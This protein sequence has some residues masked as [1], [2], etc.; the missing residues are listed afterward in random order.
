MAIGDDLSAMLPPP[1]PP[2]PMRRD[3]T[4]AAALRR[5]DG[6]PDLADPAV[7]AA[8]PGRLHTRRA[9]VLASVLLVAVIGVPATLI[10]LRDRP[11]ET[12]REATSTQGE[13]APPPPTSAAPSA[14]APPGQVARDVS[15]P[16]ADRAQ[17]GAPIP[18][19]Q[20]KLVPAP[21]TS[22]AVQQRA[23]AVGSLA[24]APV[25]APPPPPP[26]PPPAPA[27]AAP[28]KP[29]EIANRVE[30]AGA[31]DANEVVVTGSRVR[32]KADLRD[33]KSAMRATERPNDSLERFGRMADG[34][35]R[36]VGAFLDRA[37]AYQRQGKLDLALA[38]LNRAH[39]RAPNDPRILRQRSA[40][41]RQLGDTRRAARD[42]RL[43]R[44]LDAE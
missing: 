41:Y 22:F 7:A 21:T 34:E 35:T 27:A 38:E 42:E 24:E 31:L 23:E 40:L 25:V 6:E 43:L 10:R 39:R 30:E 15:P 16:I 11:V 8:R 9:G 19:P 3:A 26:P 20:A 33:D 32:S 18:T 29:R 17:R 12:V 2:R 4:I 1:P 5:F 13:T 36:S 37:L 14:V 28:A 44:E